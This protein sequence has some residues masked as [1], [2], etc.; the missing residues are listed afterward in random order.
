MYFSKVAFSSKE[1]KNLFG[2]N[3]YIL[4]SARLFFEEI[5]STT[6]KDFF[7]LCI[8]NSLQS[9]SCIHKG[10]QRTPMFIF[11]SSITDNSI[12]SYRQPQLLVP[13]QWK[14]QLDLLA[15]FIF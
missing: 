8:R 5:Q 9:A 15:T 1:K 4:H 2:I 13:L 12:H 11:G 6:N 10:Q 3:S 7:F 14:E